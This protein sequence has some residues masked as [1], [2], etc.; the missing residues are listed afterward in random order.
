MDYV[1]PLVDEQ[2]AG[3]PQH[4]PSAR[5]PRSKTFLVTY[6]F[7]SGGYGVPFYNT[8]MARDR[9]SAV[10][11]AERYLDSFYGPKRES[12]WERNGN[13]W[14]YHLGAVTVKLGGVEELT[15]E[16]VVRRLLIP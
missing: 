12:D 1:T 7:D 8:I 3:N 11:K 5:R 13:T 10:K 16:Q 15:P 2:L 4:D 6:D 14:S 9:D